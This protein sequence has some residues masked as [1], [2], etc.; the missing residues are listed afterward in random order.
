MQERYVLRL[1]LRVY[2]LITTFNRKKKKKIGLP[3]D[4][5]YRSQGYL[6]YPSNRYVLKCILIYYQTDSTTM[7]WFTCK[8]QIRAKLFFNPCS[9]EPKT[10]GHAELT[11]ATV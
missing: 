11:S 1:L 4:I 6:P 9:W 10:V 8:V 2:L 5:H 3:F 7:N